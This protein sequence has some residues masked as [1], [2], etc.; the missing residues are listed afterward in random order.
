[1]TAFLVA[2]AGGYGMFL[3]Y[4]AVAF[5]WRGVGVGPS[6]MASRRR[7]HLTDWLTQA[8]FDDV[9]P[10]ELV[11]VSAALL[12]VGACVG[13]AVFGGAVP[14][15]AAGLFAGTVPI[16]SARGRRSRRRARAREAWPRML[17]EIRVLTGAVGRS[18][19]QA[20]FEV[21]RQSPH[22]L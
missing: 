3:L 10:G 20:L 7:P 4:T 6:V 13:F 11:A 18:I 14:A 5:G 19:P 2:L 16:A 15:V 1:M 12:V 21:G 22:E 8:G 17:E 9:K